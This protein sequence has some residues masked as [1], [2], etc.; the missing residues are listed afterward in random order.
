MDIESLIYNYMAR[1]F[2]R[3]QAIYMINQDERN[4]TYQSP[5][6]RIILLLLNPH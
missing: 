3:E 1:G 6:V 5:Y 2:S 4:L